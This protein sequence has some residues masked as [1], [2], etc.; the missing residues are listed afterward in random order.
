M[1]ET[2]KRRVV[3][4]GMGVVSALGHDAQC[5]WQ[6]LID[7]RS[8]IAPID[9]FGAEG[10]RNDLAGQVRE[11]AFDPSE[12]GLDE[13]P[14]LATQFLL[15]AAAEAVRDAGLSLE[16]G[17]VAQRVGIVASTNFGGAPSWEAYVAGLLAGEADPRLF[18][19]FSF[20]SGLEHVVARFGLG[21]SAGLLSV[22]CASGTAALG[23]AA[24]AIRLGQAEVMLAAGYDALAQTPLAGL[25]V[26]HTITAEHI[27]PF[28][29][30]RSGTLFGEGSAVLV[31]EDYAAATSRGAS[32]Y[33]EVLGWAENSN[34]YHLTAPDNEGAGMTRVVRAALGDGAVAPEEIDYVNAHGTGTQ[35]HDPAETT[36]VKAVLGQRAHEIPM[37]SI[38]AAVGHMMGAAGAAEAIASVRAITDGIVPPT[39]NYREPDPEC[40]LDYVPNE[41][42]AAR[43]GK[44]LSISAGIGGNNACVVLGAA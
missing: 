8:G 10:L 44:A 42:R 36:A 40:D 2:A 1:S 27:R 28:S 18:E 43:V 22:A 33:A 21:G 5:F 38:K 20:H 17:E 13:A 19:E 14:D 35:P 25:S 24:D 41:S 7:N 37:T 15:V 4:T 39:L 6:G 34:A 29:A 3:I 30:D 23:A 31:V 9:R 11:W 12:L 32:I 16:P 26:L